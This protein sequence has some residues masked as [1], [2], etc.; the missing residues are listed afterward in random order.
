VWQKPSNRPFVIRTGGAGVS[1]STGE[2]HAALAELHN[3]QPLNAIT[4]SVRCRLGVANGA[5]RVREDVGRHN[6]LDK[7]IGALVRAG[8]DCS[9]GYM[10]ITSRASYDGGKGHRRHHL[11]G[12][13]VPT[14]WRSGWPKRLVCHWSALCVSIIVVY[15]HARRLT[16]RQY[17][18]MHIERLDHGNDIAAFFHGAANQERPR[19]A[20]PSICALWDPRMRKQIIAHVQAMEG[21]SELARR[22]VEVLAVSVKAQEEATA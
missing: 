9:T 3:R 14:G 11:A 18:D 12:G 1:I 16:D 15:A 4:G 2:L 8:I 21:L 13:G 19:T 20:S 6:A 5:F 7:V 22:G 17:D 10:I